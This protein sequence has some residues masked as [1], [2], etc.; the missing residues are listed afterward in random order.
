MLLQRKH[1]ALQLY[2]SAVRVTLS[3]FQPTQSHDNLL[4]CILQIYMNSYNLICTGFEQ[5]AHVPYIYIY[6]CA[7]SS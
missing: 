2:I 4:F 7:F 6:I 3:Y 1:L 5:P